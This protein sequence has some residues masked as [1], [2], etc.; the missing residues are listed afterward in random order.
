MVRSLVDL[1]GKSFY[2]K[3]FK[4]CLLYPVL[5]WVSCIDQKREMYNVCK[6]ERT[7]SEASHGAWL[8]G[9]TEE[10]VPPPGVSIH[11]PWWSGPEVGR[12]HMSRELK[13]F[14]SFMFSTKGE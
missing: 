12:R 14:L 4:I 3:I 9:P 7:G 5:L 2:I 10:D 6:G 1:Q 11:K 13:S 8:A